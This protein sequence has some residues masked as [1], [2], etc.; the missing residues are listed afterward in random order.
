VDYEV[1]YDKAR[2]DRAAIHRFLSEDAYWSRGIPRTVVDAAIEHSLVAGV[3]ADEGAQAAYARVVS[4]RATFAWLADVFV[5][6][7][8]RGRGL[9][10]R[11][12]EAA[13]AH[14]AL[15]TEP[16]LRSWILRTND[17]HELYRPYGF[18]EPAEPT[19]VMVRG[20]GPGVYDRR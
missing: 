18:A 8:H 4:D 11:V 7:G 9:G 2:L 3:Y 16:P 20:A 13:L 15:P 6:P 1:S 17:A 19:N 10:R 14:P 5:L 12:V